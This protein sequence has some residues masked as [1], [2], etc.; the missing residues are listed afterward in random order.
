MLRCSAVYL[1]GTYGAMRGARVNA[2]PLLY[3]GKRNK[4]VIFLFSIQGSSCIIIIR[5]EVI[6]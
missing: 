6:L 5:M 4:F 2:L 1:T 3:C